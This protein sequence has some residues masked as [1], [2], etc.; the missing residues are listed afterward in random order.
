MDVYMIRQILVERDERGRS[1]AE[2]E[3]RM[4]L[5]KGVVDRLGSKGVI[6]L[7]QEVGRAQKNV[8]IV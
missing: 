7:A 8:E 2:I 6:A 1:A 5:K 4:G 3:R